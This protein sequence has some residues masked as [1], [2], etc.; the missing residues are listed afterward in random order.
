[1]RK[2]LLRKP[3]P[4]A[5]MQG[6][7]KYPSLAIIPFNFLYTGLSLSSSNLAYRWHHGGVVEAAVG[8]VVLAFCTALPVVLYCSYLSR[9]AFHATTIPDPRLA[10]ADARKLSLLAGSSPRSGAT[11]EAAEPLF[12]GDE[13]QE[14]AP[15]G[16]PSDAPP[17]KRQ[18]HVFKEFADHPLVQNRSR[19]DA[20]G[21]ALSGRQHPLLLSAADP[22][23][24]S[25]GMP[26]LEVAGLSLSARSDWTEGRAA[27]DE[28][29]SRGEPGSDAC[30]TPPGG[31][32]WW[33]GN[34]EEGAA[35]TGWRR[36]VRVFF[37]GDRVWVN[38]APVDH[39]F[40][41]ERYG[42][43][44]EAYREGQHHFLVLEMTSIVGLCILSAWRPDIAFRC[45]LRNSLLV[46][47]LF[48]YQALVWWY[49]PY[50]AAFDNLFFMLMTL[51]LT[52]A[53]LLITVALALERAP[54]DPAVSLCTGVATRLLV[55]SAYTI[56]VKAVN[57]FCMVLREISEKKRVLFR[58][59]AEDAVDTDQLNRASADGNSDDSRMGGSCEPLGKLSP[60]LSAG[61]RKS[62]GGE[63][64]HGPLDIV[65][66][67]A[68]PVLSR[69]QSRTDTVLSP[70]HVAKHATPP[71]PASPHDPSPKDDFSEVLRKC[72]SLALGEKEKVGRAGSSP[73]GDHHHHHHHHPE[74]PD[75]AGLRSHASS[76]DAVRRVVDPAWASHPLFK[77]QSGV[78]HAT[79]PDPPAHP[80]APSPDP[81]RASVHS[82]RA[83][84]DSQTKQSPPRSPNSLADPFD[85][86]MRRLS[87]LAAQPPPPAFQA[88]STE[89]PW[90]STSMSVDPLDVSVQSLVQPPKTPVKARR[91]T[92]SAYRQSPDAIRKRS[93]TSL[94]LPALSDIGSLVSRAAPLVRDKDE[95]DSSEDRASS[96]ATQY[97]VGNFSPTEAGRRLPFSSE[98]S[99]TSPTR[100]NSRLKR[101][102]HSFLPPDSKP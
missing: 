4:P 35:V 65:G 28:P 102:T 7:V 63:I 14:A 50:L 85:H 3:T 40:F 51:F 64:F 16:G 68:A 11:E 21:F 47:V 93:S 36:S 49:R 12:S 83:F 6:I 90:R 32:T 42:A 30:E 97:P 54:S 71:H 70:V 72:S 91:Y 80:R 46:G 8:C 27:S 89:A 61:E 17:A 5:F 75:P 76:S 43:M 69:T 79:P 34:P 23:G 53:V 9:P 96:P 26:S 48:V 94:L 98:P 29:S 78:T 38:T 59:M 87:P 37:L 56:A 88:F 18:R 60:L 81:L 57:D 10:P 2:R 74:D 55:A 86:S 1:M 95:A 45:H 41:V 13:P 39:P 82:L 67:P 31:V 92:A 58:A 62:A 22:L 25:E 44:F 73:A 20:S 15:A 77:T 84:S 99:A 33:G 52:S 19:R 100:Q 101:H 24:A 66:S